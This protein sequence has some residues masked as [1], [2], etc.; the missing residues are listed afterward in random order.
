LG[1]NTG[2]ATV[3]RNVLN[4]L[5]PYYD[6]HCLSHNCF[7]Q[8]LMPGVTFID[9]EKIDFT[10]HGSGQAKYSVDKISPLIKNLKA[11]LFCIL[12]DTFMMAEGG[13]MGIDTSPARTAFYYPSDGGGGLPKG[14]ENILKKVNLPIAMARYGRDQAKIAHGIDS[15]YIPHGYDP[16]VYYQLNKEERDKLRETWM[17]RD[18]FVVGVMGRNQGR[19]MH[20]RALKAFKLFSIDKP[21]AVLLLHLDPNDPAQTFNINDLINRYKLN[22]R[23]LFTGTSFY[24]PFTYTAMNN[25]YN[26]MDIYFSSTSGEGFGLGTIEAMACGVPQVMPDYTNSRE[27]LLDDGIETGLLVKLAGESD[28]IVTP[29]CDEVLDGTLTGSWDVERGVMSIYDAV[30]QLNKLYNDRE[31]LKKFSEASVV[32]A[33]KF[34]TWDRVASL[35]KEVFDKLL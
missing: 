7:T 24:N 23:V 25:V 16:K 4:R 13:F 14:C 35:F 22:N 9:G 30:E 31:L 10:I 32:K 20:D 18:K 15:A 5:S 12:L 17:L 26:L 11:D 21:D 34:Y 6:I 19:K 27:L 8:T 28:F 3:T 29:H 1:S 33:K 2:Y